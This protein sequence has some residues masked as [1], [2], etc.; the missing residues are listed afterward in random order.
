MHGKGTYYFITGGLI[1]KNDPFERF[2]ATGDSIVGT[3]YD[4]ELD[5]GN[6]YGNN[7]VLKERIILSRN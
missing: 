6:H 1:S 3:W 7:G 4:G 2:A 5:R